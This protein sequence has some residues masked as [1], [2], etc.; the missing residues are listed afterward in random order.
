MEK[1]DAGSIELDGRRLEKLKVHE[2]ALF[3]VRRCFQEVSIIETLS[4]LDNLRVVVDSGAKELIALLNAVG[5]PAALTTSA[6]LSYGQKK[7][8]DVAR[9]LAEPTSIRLLLLD[10]PT[11]G[12]DS[13]E[14]AAV[15]AA[16]QSRQRKIGFSIVFASHDDEFVTAMRPTI[17]Y[18]LGK[19]RVAVEGS[20]SDVQRSAEFREMFWGVCHEENS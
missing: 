20:L 2:P 17:T 13:E 10:E 14:S 3:G 11:A 15:A 6:S 16:I 7:L 19:G 18:G 12:L 9:C 1:C 5:I 4:P 8:L